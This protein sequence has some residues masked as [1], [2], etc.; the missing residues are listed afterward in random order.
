MA[1]RP[2]FIQKTSTCYR[3]LSDFITD[4]NKK[5]A[6]TNTITGC[7]KAI[8]MK[9]YHIPEVPW[10]KYVERGERGGGVIN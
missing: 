8:N 7:P 2:A 9:Y 10:Q 4:H 1:P 3:G 6:I 5:T